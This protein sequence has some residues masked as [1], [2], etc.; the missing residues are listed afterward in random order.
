MNNLAAQFRESWSRDRP[1]KKGTVLLA[2]SGGLD[3]MVMASLFLSTGLPFAIAHCNF[4]L[5]GAES[6]GDEALVAGWCKEQG[7][8]FF[9]RQFD[10][11]NIAAHTGK[12]IQEVAR[13]LR[14]EWFEQLRKECGFAAVC[15]AHH[16][17]DSAETILMNL[18]RGTGIAGLHGI[19]ARNGYLLRPLL[20]A[21]RKALEEFAA[22]NNIPYRTDSS[23]NTDDYL[24]NALR[25]HVIPVL[26]QRM[27]GAAGRIQTT[28][29][30]VGEAEILYRKEIER[31][32]KKLLQARGKDYYIPIKML[33][34]R[35]P[36]ATILYELILPFGFTAAQL[37][38]AV[39]LL[40][41]ESGRYLASATH[42]L[43]RNRDFLIITT[44]EETGADLIP[45]ANLNRT[46]ATANGTFVFKIM[47][48]IPA[49]VNPG[50]GTVLVDA[51]KLTTPIQLRRWKQG[52]YFYPLGMEMKKKKLSRFLIDQK[53]PVHEKEKI[54][55]LE[56]NKR[57]VWIAGYRL[58]ERFKITPST[59]EI[60]SISFNKNDAQAAYNTRH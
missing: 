15:T 23:N 59:K 6:D 44:V 5:R 56:S 4:N 35:V 34:H 47:P 18:C 21:N 43:I 2:V 36:L 60:L 48:T 16:A 33:Q 49:A 58:D 52:D 26:E 12:G 13:N 45:V 14:Y 10:T 25:H 3:S 19:P 9:V 24:R 1:A 57:I 22:A 30:L 31:E 40:N 20:F 17:D 55:L 8:P 53:V 29:R 38:D 51:S 46:V 37:D 11:G 32:R 28:G 7:I 54:W 42:R 41:A 39:Q 50:S 27:P